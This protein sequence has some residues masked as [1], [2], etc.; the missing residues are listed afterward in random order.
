M[1]IVIAG[2]GKLGKY[3]TN[4]LV[5]EDNEI[6]LV[7]INFSGKESLINNEDVNYVEGNALDSNIL[8]EAGISDADLL[9]SVM[10]SD[11]ENMMCSL[12]GKK[13]GAKHTIARIR[14]PEYF[15]SVNIIRDMLGL[16]MVINPEA[17]AAAQIAQALRV[18][19]DS[20]L[21]GENMDENKKYSNKEILQNIINR[22]DDEELQVLKDIIVATFPNLDKIKE[23][24][25]DKHN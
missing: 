22:C 17:L 23:K 9:I 21:Y 3:L 10:K 24:K 11:S 18:T 2:I 16:S 25:K 5:K 20:L 15:N 12:I 19:T 1:K 8:I 14:T 4:L 13:L 6:T 7:D